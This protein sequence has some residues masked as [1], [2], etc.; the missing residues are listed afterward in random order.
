MNENFK[1]W[2]GDSKVIDEDG[3][4]LVVYHGSNNDI[5]RFHSFSKTM[6]KRNED[7]M[8]DSFVQFG[9]FFS[10]SPETADFYAETDRPTQHKID[11]KERVEAAHKSMMETKDVKQRI[12]VFNKYKKIED[13]YK[14]GV[15]NKEIFEYYSDTIYPVYL[16][17]QNPLIVEGEG[18]SWFKVLP[19]I[20]NNFDYE[21]YDGIIFK[22]IIEANSI[23]QTTYVTFQP[24]QI[25][26]AVGNNGDFNP[27][28]P[29]ITMEK[30]GGVKTSNWFSGE[31]SFL[32]W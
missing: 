15:K 26:S 12:E 29:D 4:P 32:N 5:R 9:N 17:L 6:K 19:D 8:F 7:D 10:S 20:Y 3:N 11:S 16:S 30:G 25:K 23:V 31:L 21:R 13:K 18:K 1:I 14:E 28:N 22:D 2:F 27:N 24:S